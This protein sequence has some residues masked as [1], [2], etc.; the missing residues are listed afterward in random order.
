VSNPTLSLSRWSG[1]GRTDFT[2]ELD[3]PNIAA[4]PSHDGC[5][6]RLP[7]SAKPDEV[8]FG[9]SL[10]MVH[11]KLVIAESAANNPG[12]QI[13]MQSWYPNYTAVQVPLTWRD[14]ALAEIAR[15]SDDVTCLLELVAIANIRHQP[16]HQPA[17]SPQ[18]PTQAWMTS[19]VRDNG[20]GVTFTLL[21]QH[22]LKLLKDGGF[23]R[24]RLVELP[25]ASGAVGPVWSECMRLLQRATGELRSGQSE[26]AVGTSREVVEGI[27][28]VFEQ[29]FGLSA[30]KGKSLPDRAKELAGRIG[31]AWPDD[32]YAGEMLA[33]LYGAAWS[34]TS[35]EHHYGSRVPRHDE[36]EFAVELTA[37]L[38]THA[39]HL[40]QAHPDPIKTKAAA[41]PATNGQH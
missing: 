22:W 6:L 7:M 15:K 34:W 11:G 27:V 29:Q 40:L 12:I 16:P 32:K 25:V 31:S 19:V 26:V 24:V 20:T 37:A 8:G 28:S 2:I 30:P 10:L 9:A 38:L 17:Q 3:A 13:P 1:A 4:V 36:A 35:S 14:M 5:M 33:G 21:K 41:E 39:G 23:E 18:W